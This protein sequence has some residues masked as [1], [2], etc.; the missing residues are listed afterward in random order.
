MADAQPVNRKRLLAPFAWAVAL[1][2]PPRCLGCGLVVDPDDSLCASCWGALS[3][4]G[5]P[6]CAGCGVPFAVILGQDELCAPRSE[7]SRVGKECVCTRSSRWSPY[8]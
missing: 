8:P 7:G 4:I 3:F 2:L 5:A 1:A 6:R